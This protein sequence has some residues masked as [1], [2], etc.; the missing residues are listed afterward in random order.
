MAIDITIP[1]EIV[2]IFGEA[3]SFWKLT[4]PDD[5]QMSLNEWV[6]R[7]IADQCMPMLQDFQSARVKTVLNT[8]YGG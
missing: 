1:D 7:R 3:F 6:V 4:H 2:D 8:L 5:E